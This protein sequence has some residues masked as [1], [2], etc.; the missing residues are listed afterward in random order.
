M[1]DQAFMDISMFRC[2]YCGKLYADS[3][4][5]IVELRSDIECGVCHEEFNPSKMLK[6]RVILSLNVNGEDKVSEVT[7]LE[8]V[9]D[10]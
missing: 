9:K 7:I 1:N 4:W 10:F 6:D 5:Y 8:H 3:S 2:P